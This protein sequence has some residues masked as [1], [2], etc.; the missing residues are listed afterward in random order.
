[1][2]DKPYGR[3][4]RNARTIPVDGRLRTVH[5]L[6][7]DGLWDILFLERA[8]RLLLLLVVDDVD[9]EVRT[10]AA[11][12]ALAAA[13]VLSERALHG[14][15][16]FAQEKFLVRARRGDLPG[17][18]LVKRAR[19]LAVPADVD[20]A[21]LECS[22]PDIAPKKIAPTVELC[23]V[24][25]R[26]LEHAR[27]AAV[28]ARECTLD[29]GET[30]VMVVERD[31]A[32]L[33]VLLEQLLPPLE[34]R[35]RHLAEPLERRIGL[36]HEAG[37]G[38]RD[39]DAALALDLRV[40]VD[41]LLREARDADDIVVRLRRQA[42]H[43][44]ELDLLPPLTKRRAARRHEVFLRDALVDD[45]AQALRTSLRRERQAGLP[46]L[47]HLVRE[48][49]G[50]AVDA[51][52]WQREA[53]LLVAELVHEIVDKTAETGIV[54]RGERGEAHLVVPRAVDEPA[55]HLFQVLL[56]AFARGAVADA[57]LAEAAAA[58]AT[59]EELKHDTVVHDV[60]VG[61][62][63][64]RDTRHL[65]HILH[66]AL[67]DDGTRLL[68]ARHKR[69]ETPIGRVPRRIERRHIDAVDCEQAAQEPLTPI[70]PAL[71]L[72]RLIDI[73]NLE[74]HLLALA[75]D[76]EIKEIR[77]RLDIVDARPAADDEG[78]RLR[79]LC[80]VERDAR[81]VEHVEHVRVNHLVL[82]REAEEGEAADLC[83]RLERIERQLPLPHDGLHVRPR[84]ID[85]LG[86]DIRAAV[87]D[88]IEDREPQV[89]HADL[90]DVGEREGKGATHLVR[91]LADGIPL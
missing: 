46:H 23:A 14:L 91:V 32:V 48:V 26:L 36:R 41:D 24:A 71:C 90:I 39:L 33:D 53:D 8:A 13:A 1:M 28:A 18:R 37:D 73:D 11:G 75:H 45:V 85:T 47:L 2:R 76:E 30:R 79:A 83:L 58:R 55:R 87:E 4:L 64:M 84:R 51:Q 63:G 89:A 9:A 44:I 70:R 50:K 65:V 43:E 6:R 60:H 69:P 10:D 82:Q 3:V 20:A 78:I 49:D 66:N 56:R 88:F 7:M 5:L 77:N 52:R 22:V 54:R 40:E 67:V 57:R 19:A 81:E 15:L 42:H 21:F 61:H 80:R 25:P 17:Q 34:L 29:D 38:D 72:P 35:E 74:K 31:C 59:A 86:R 16:P 12:A 27:E 68:R 62:N